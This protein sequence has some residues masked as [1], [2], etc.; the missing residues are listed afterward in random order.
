MKYGLSAI[1]KKRM[2]QKTKKAVLVMV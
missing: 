2:C 1:Q